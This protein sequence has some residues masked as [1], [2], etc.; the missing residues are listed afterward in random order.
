MYSGAMIALKRIGKS[1]RNYTCAQ[2][3]AKDFGWIWA[4]SLEAERHNHRA[5]KDLFKEIGVPEK[6]IRDGDR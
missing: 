2:I 1:S 4:A 5:Y 3:F 6:M